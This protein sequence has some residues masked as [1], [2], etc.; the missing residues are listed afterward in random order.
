MSLKFKRDAS[1]ENNYKIQATAMMQN[2]A[3]VHGDTGSN[4]MRTMI[5]LI[6]SKTKQS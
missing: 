4:M 6:D 5:M 3:V 2:V 1:C